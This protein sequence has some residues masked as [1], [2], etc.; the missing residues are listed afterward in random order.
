MSDLEMW[1]L[2]V[3]VLLPIVVATINRSVW[4]G[5][6]KAAV[7]IVTSSAAGGV[8]AWLT[9]VLTGG[10]WLHSALVVGVAAVGSW[11]VFWRPSGIGPAVERATEPGLPSAHVG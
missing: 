10:T 1:S 8:T 7:V 2:L 9:G 11:R 5:W 6:A 4:P 3:G